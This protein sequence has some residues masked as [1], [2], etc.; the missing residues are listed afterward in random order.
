M[1]REQTHDVFSVTGF[2][3]TYLQDREQGTVRTLADY[4]ALYPGQEL[5]IAEAWVSLQRNQGALGHDNQRDLPVSLGLGT[6]L[7]GSVPDHQADRPGRPGRGVP[8]RGLPPCT[9][10]WPS[11]C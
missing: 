1:D 6:K 9:A 10:R 7:G 2:L 8:G 5:A 3:H 4:L 11:R